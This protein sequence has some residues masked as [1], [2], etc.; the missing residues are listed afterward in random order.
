MAVVTEP[1]RRSRSAAR[2]RAHVVHRV[3]TLWGHLSSTST[4]GRP[5]PEA[6]ASEGNYDNAYIKFFTGAPEVGASGHRS[7][8]RPPPH[9]RTCSDNFPALGACAVHKHEDW[10]GC[11]VLAVRRDP[12]TPSLF[13]FYLRKFITGTA[14]IRRCCP[15]RWTSDPGSSDR[16]LGRLL[17]LHHQTARP[18][19][20]R[21]RRQGRQQ[22]LRTRAEQPAP[23]WPS[24]LPTSSRSC[25]RTVG[26]SLVKVV[27]VVKVVYL[28]LHRS[29]GRRVEPRRLRS[30]RLIN[31]L[32]SG[33][34]QS[35]TPRRHTMGVHHFPTLRAP[36]HTVRALDLGPLVHPPVGV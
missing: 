24:S 19:C 2:R 4:T 17:G 9:L 35:D 22:P 31:P 28:Q 14:P 15:S 27:K 34:F 1:S 10:F 13:K 25:T 5:V 26:G 7:A 3:C 36:G 6:R 32:V 33:G 12:P 11:I 20:G 23:V 29:C 21:L 8:G 30:R 16:R 18:W